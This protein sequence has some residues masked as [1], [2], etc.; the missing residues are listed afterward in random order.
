MCELSWRGIHENNGRHNNALDTWNFFWC[1][2]NLLI[3]EMDGICGWLLKEN[4]IKY[5]RDEKACVF[6]K[7]MLVAPQNHA[8]QIKQMAKA[9]CFALYCRRISHFVH[10]AFLVWSLLKRLH[11]I[12]VGWIE[13]AIGLSSWMLGIFSLPKPLM[14]FKFCSNIYTYIQTHREREKKKES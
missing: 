14:M 10:A 7:K 8:A 9:A 6:F 2:H 11:T 5:Y 3:V 13:E 12:G 4:N 1:G